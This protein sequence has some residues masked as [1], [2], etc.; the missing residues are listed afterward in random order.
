MAKDNF[1]LHEWVGSKERRLL[2][3][4]Y[5]SYNEGQEEDEVEEVITYNKQIGTKADHAN[6]ENATEEE[7]K[8]AYDK[9]ITTLQ[10]ETL[11]DLKNYVA[12]VGDDKAKELFTKLDTAVKDFDAYMA[13]G[14]DFML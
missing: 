4:D 2:K 1:N 5:N 3:E 6:Y 14:D 9:I 13:H 12:Q 8:E 11:V 7:K 10:K